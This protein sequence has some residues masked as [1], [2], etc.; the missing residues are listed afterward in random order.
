MVNPRPRPFR[1]P[2][3]V[4]VDELSMSTSE[5]FAGGMK[6]IGKR[7]SSARRRRAR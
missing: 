2:V 4:L 5:I 6:D 7:G 1:G 3:A